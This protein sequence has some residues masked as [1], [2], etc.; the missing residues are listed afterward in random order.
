MPVGFSLCYIWV[1]LANAAQ[2]KLLHSCIEVAN[3]FEF[4]PSRS[5]PQQAYQYRFCFWRSVAQWIAPV[6]APSIAHS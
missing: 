6:H 4:S 1:S 5:L 3:H 2:G